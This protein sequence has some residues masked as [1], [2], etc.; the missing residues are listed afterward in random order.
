MKKRLLWTIWTAMS[1]VPKKADKLNL[2]LNPRVFYGT[3][4]GMEKNFI[5]C[6]KPC[7]SDEY[8]ICLVLEKLYHWTRSRNK[9]QHLSYI[10]CRKCA[11][12]SIYCTIRS[13][14]TPSKLDRRNLHMSVSSL[15][16]Y[17]VKSSPYP[18][19]VQ[20]AV[21]LALKWIFLYIVIPNMA[22]LVV[23]LKM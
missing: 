1:S 15:T 22:L 9:L 13:P 16:I 18:V 4:F 19:S 6:Q 7:T 2:S 8:L 12:N 3:K 20:A 5:I 21:F 23:H 14:C 11:R 17:R 10:I